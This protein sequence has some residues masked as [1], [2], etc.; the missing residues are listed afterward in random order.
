MKKPTILSIAISV[1]IAFTS[2]KKDEDSP[3]TSSEPSFSADNLSVTMDENP[4]QGDLV[5]LI[6]FEKDSESTVLT[7][8]LTTNPGN[9]MTINSSTGRV[10]VATP[11]YFDYESRESFSGKAKISDGKNSKTINITVTL[12]DVEEGKVPIDRVAL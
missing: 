8:T 7:F 9:A 5:G 12:N 2:C 1:L 6:A 11:S 4:N 10:T 3:S